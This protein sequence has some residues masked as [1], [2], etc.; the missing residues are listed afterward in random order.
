MKMPN[1]YKETQAAGEFTPIELGAHYMIIKSVVE[2]N[3][4][5]TPIKTKNGIPMIK[6]FFDFA[7]NDKQP[8]YFLNQYRNDF[9]PRE[10]G[11]EKEWPFAGTAY[12]MTETNEGVCSPRYKAFITSVEKSNPGFAVWWAEDD[13]PE[14]SRRWCEQFKNKSVGGVFQEVIDVYDSGKGLKESKKHV[15]NR[16]CSAD[17][18]P[19]IAAPD[20][21]ETLAHKSWKESG[22]ITTAKPDSMGFMNIPDNLDSEELPFN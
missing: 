12:I 10:N 21:Y 6:V 4:D 7:Q 14:A 3:Q 11:K 18:V 17:K 19:E 9:R 22:G 20:P 15:L 2:R 1:R 13:S 16:F 8:N 5:G